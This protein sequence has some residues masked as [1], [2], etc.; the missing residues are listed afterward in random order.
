MRGGRAGA[1]VALLAAAL[2]V[3]SVLAS[4]DGVEVS[5][6]R[7]W[8]SEHHDRG[9]VVGQGVRLLGTVRLTGRDSHGLSALAWDADAERL[10][11]VSDLGRLV[12]FRLI[13][14]GDFLVGAEA[15]WSG[16]LR[17]RSGRPLRGKT[18]TDAEGMAWVDGEHPLCISFERQ[19]RVECFDR[20]GRAG[21]SVALSGPLRG[22]G[23]FSGSNSGLESLMAHPR[24][25]LVAAPERP[26][27]GA[28]EKQLP[29]VALSDG[30]YW[31]HT[32]SERDGCAQTA[33]EPMHDDAVLV[34]ERCWVGPG[35]PLVVYLREGRLNP[36]GVRVKDLLEL[37]SGEGWK[38]DNFEGLAGVGR[39]RFVM[40]SDDNGNLWQ[41]TLL[42]MFERIE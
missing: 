17:M 12:E 39:N 37:H 24:W 26:L 14:E 22:S 19:H 28:S 23:R 2:C 1:V 27:H 15:L 42:V 5:A 36:E 40:I 4:G 32:L 35:I 3:R 21:E 30:R 9:E 10:F 31:N 20:R 8:L 11:A 16:P 18:L 25:G 7:F 13:M 34:L 6:Q 41:Q 33:M 29:W 38:V